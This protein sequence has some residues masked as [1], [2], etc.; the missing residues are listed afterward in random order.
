MKIILGLLII[1]NVLFFA[2]FN[3]GN[4][5]EGVPAQAALQAE[6]IQLLSNDGVSQQPNPADKKVLNALSCME[7]SDFSGT[8]LKRANNALASLNWGEKLSQ[9]P[10]EYNSGF[11][12]Y[13]PPLKNKIAVA[14]K[15][16]QLKAR[17]VEEYF[18]V[19]EPGMWQ[20]A[21]SLGVFKTEDAARN[22]L[23]TLKNKDVGSAKVGARDSKLRATIFVFEQLD[24][25]MVEQLMQLQ[26]EFPSSELKRLA[27]K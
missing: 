21:I 2:W 12:A 20:H 15:I 11:W 16:E 18:V 13:I 19:Q 22:F 26:R 25:A 17:G 1:A 14:Q 4:V 10:I 3:W 7:W 24:E 27:C 6:K 8:D 23:A 9:R 5:H